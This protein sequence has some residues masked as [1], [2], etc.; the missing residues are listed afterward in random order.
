MIFSSSKH[1]ADSHDLMLI[2]KSIEGDSHAFAEIMSLYGKRVYIL[3]L[4]FFKN[5]T[6]AEDFTQDVFI[7]TYKALASFKNQS[8]FSTWLM[9]IAYNTAINTINRRKEYVSL[10]EN[11]EIL[12]TD[13]GP[14]EQQL[15]L[16]SAKAIRQAIKELPYNFAICLDLF[17]FYDFTHKEISIIT[18]LPINTI[19]SHIFRAKKILKHKLADYADSLHT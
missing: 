6:D 2:K 16:L 14:E 13:Y 11:I 7:K 9:K 3:G 4:G 5:T 12:D 15:R 19:K 10:S 1:Q 8:L 17:F 18:G